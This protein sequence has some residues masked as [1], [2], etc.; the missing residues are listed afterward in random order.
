MSFARGT[1]QHGIASEVAQAQR[2]SGVRPTRAT[3]DRCANPAIRALVAADCA[4]QAVAGKQLLLTRE[5]P[6]LG[7]SVTLLDSPESVAGMQQSALVFGGPAEPSK[8][9]VTQ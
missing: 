6:K 3:G 2:D 8:L 1:P 7:S 9:S 4:A 5:S